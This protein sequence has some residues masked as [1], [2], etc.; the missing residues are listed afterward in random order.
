MAVRGTGRCRTSNKYTEVEGKLFFNDSMRALNGSMRQ[1]AKRFAKTPQ[2]TQECAFY[3]A[4]IENN[5]WVFTPIGKR[6]N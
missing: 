6:I 4:T 1:A 5:R 3:S 2:F